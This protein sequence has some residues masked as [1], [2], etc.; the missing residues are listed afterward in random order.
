[1]EI[2]TAKHSLIEKKRKRKTSVGTRTVIFKK[3]PLRLFYLRMQIDLFYL[4]YYSLTF[5]L[6]DLQA[7]FW[8]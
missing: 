4:I 8:C 1:M 6:I 2:K 5:T 7:S 3:T